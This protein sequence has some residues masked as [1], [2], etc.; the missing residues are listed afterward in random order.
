[1]NKEVEMKNIPS[2]VYS[3][4]PRAKKAD[5]KLLRALQIA[6]ATVCASI[7]VLTMLLMILPLFRVQSIQVEGNG[8]Y[9]VK[10]IMELSGI[11]EGDEL[12]AVDAQKAADAI[13]ATGYFS[14][15]SVS[16]KF[17]GIV[18]INV[19]EKSNLMYTEYNGQY[20][21]LDGSFCVLEISDTSEAFAGLFC[22]ELPQFAAPVVGSKLCFY[23]DVNMDYV[24]LLAD[25]LQEN[26]LIDYVTV[27]DCS[28]KYNV[29]FVLNNTLRMEV[30]KVA[31][32][33][34]KLRLAERILQEK[35]ADGS[36]YVTLDVSNL[37]KST[38]RVLSA[39][40]FMALG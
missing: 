35:A 13:Y 6:I 17:P 26:G 20:L 16:G 40:E 29:S 39:D 15:V 4:K 25:S 33:N 12:L 1:M 36:N 22:V 2:A 38:Y 18:C 14:S 27:A 8:F 30:G 34:A 3:D 21:S 31:D 24:N 28:Q 23:N 32:M 19:T 10:T 5:K 11:H 37:Q 7:F 9:S